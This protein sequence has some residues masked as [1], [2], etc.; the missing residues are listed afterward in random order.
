MSTAKEA[1]VQQVKKYLPSLQIHQ[2]MR[3]YILL[4]LL[5]IVSSLSNAQ[6]VMDGFPPTRESQVTSFN[7]REYPRSKWSF[8]NMA[9]PLHAVMIPREGPVHMFK[10]AANNNIGKTKVIKDSTFENVFDANLFDWKS[11]SSNFMPRLGEH[12]QISILR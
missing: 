5:A 3:P 8:R 7:Y 12:Q 2:H 11:E 1:P 9:A 4:I 6:K 10:R